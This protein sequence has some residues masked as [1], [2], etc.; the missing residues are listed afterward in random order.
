M[1]VG[2]GRVS[3]GGSGVAVGGSGGSVGGSGVAVGGSAVSVVRGMAVGAVGVRF[4]LLEFSHAK[5]SDTTIMP[6]ANSERGRFK[7]LVMNF[8]LI[9]I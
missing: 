7:S 1:A 3:V 5:T 2:G 8:S 9:T 6:N 4:T